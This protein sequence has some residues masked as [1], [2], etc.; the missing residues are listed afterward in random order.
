MDIMQ[1]AIAMELDGEKYYLQQAAKNEGSPLQTV[2]LSLAKDEAK[3]AKLLQSRADGQPYT[4]V[5]HDDLT[6]Q[7]SLFYKSDDF[8]S[9]VTALPNQVELYQ[10]ALDFEKKSI[11]LYSDLRCKANDVLATELFDFLI[12]EEKHHYSIIED[13]YHYANRPNEWVESAEFGVREEY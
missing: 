9:T 10:T 8:K 2:F 1:F 12:G 7:I 4:L 3:H 11:D 13:L 5:N 6:E